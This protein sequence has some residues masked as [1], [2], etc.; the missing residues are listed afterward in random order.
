MSKENTQREKQCES[1]SVQPVKLTVHVKKPSPE[2]LRSRGLQDQE[3]ATRSGSV[4]GHGLATRDQREQRVAK[5]CK[6]PRCYNEESK[7]ITIRD[8][9][10]EACG[11]H[12]QMLIN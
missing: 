10:Q 6:E 4:R 3:G 8:H 2:Y 7:G 1:F 9:R 11:C 12:S 5:S